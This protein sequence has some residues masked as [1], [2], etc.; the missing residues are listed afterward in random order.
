[1][2]CTNPSDRSQSHQATR[3][4]GITTITTRVLDYH[5]RK[6]PSGTMYTSHLQWGS[7]QNSNLLETAALPSDLL[8]ASLFSPQ[9]AIKLEPTNTW[10]IPPSF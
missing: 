7:P 4:C 1:M 10:L 5:R 2:Q 9:G 3:A 6:F 8:L